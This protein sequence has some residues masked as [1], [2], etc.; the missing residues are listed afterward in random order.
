[1]TGVSMDSAFVTDGVVNIASDGHTLAYETRDRQ[2]QLF[3]V[4]QQLAIG[5]GLPTPP[6]MERV[7]RVDFSPDARYL[8]ESYLSSS[9][10]A[11]PRTTSHPNI[12]RRSSVRN[13]AD[14]PTLSWSRSAR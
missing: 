6:H 2:I 5:S 7:T 4:D 11:S 13:S 14:L 12:G 9:G 3:D 8:E 10:S 1:M